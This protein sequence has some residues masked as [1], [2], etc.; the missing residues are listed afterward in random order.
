MLA[1]FVFSSLWYA[2]S[3]GEGQESETVD[4]YGYKF[5]KLDQGW[6]TILGTQ[7][8]VFRYNPTQL[9]NISLANVELPLS[10]QKVYF[11]YSPGDIAFDNEMGMLGSIFVSKGVRPV[12]ACI[13]EEGCPNVPIVDCND[14]EYKKIYFKEGNNSKIYL[15]GSCT[16]LEAED[17][18]SMEMLVERLYYRILG[19]MG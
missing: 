7:Q 8:L 16:V 12:K 18:L 10:E 14:E 4:Y 19:I 6:K 2:I 1:L 13:G 17:R 15:D 11:A 3:V 9:E 5:Y